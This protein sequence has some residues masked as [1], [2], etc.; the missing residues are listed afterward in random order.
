[1]AATPTVRTGPD[2]I[3]GV[4]IVA[5]STLF[6]AV[7]V[8]GRF[9]RREGFPV[10]SVLATR[11]AICAF[12]LLGLLVVLHRPLRPAPGERTAL[13]GLG[14]AGYGVESGFYF[15]AL[16]HATAAPVTLLFYTYP[17]IVALGIWAIGKGRPTR[18]TVTALVFGVLGAVIIVT[19]GGGEVR[20]ETLGIVFALCSATAYSAYLIGADRLL[21]RTD[22]LVSAMWVS[23]AAAAG[24]AVFAVATGRVVVPSGWEQWGPILGMGVFTAAAFAFLFVGLRRLGAV[25]TAIVSSTEP[26]AVSLLALGFLGE[27]IGVG[28]AIGGI[29]V[30]T[31]AI[32]SSL[33]RIAPTTE[34]QMP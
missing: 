21:V 8:L 7:A 15:A 2:P 6:A 3:G 1:M 18:R 27:T 31:A 30:V 11:F 16:G 24:H 20:M 22:P 25:R 29:L 28:I 32:I 13:V 33:A 34:P 5:S 26:L 12:L 10:S 17:V 14:V 9:I 19:L 23:A 4:Y